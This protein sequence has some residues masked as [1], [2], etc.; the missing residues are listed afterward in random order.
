MRLIWLLD[1]SV[2][3][4]TVWSPRLKEYESNILERL[5]E[6][7]GETICDRHFN[8]KN[9]LM[10][11]HHN[12]V[13]KT[14]HQIEITPSLTPSSC[15]EDLGMYAG[16]CLKCPIRGSEI[17]QKKKRCVGIKIKLYKQNSGLGRGVFGSAK[18][19]VVSSR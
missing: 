11:T 7:E 3:Q 5:W 1:D 9:V 4:V 18:A 12:L 14:H 8:K 15:K 13:S 10:A 19:C 2:A 17:F 16:P 6:A